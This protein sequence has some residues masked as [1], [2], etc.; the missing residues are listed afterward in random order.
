[1]GTLRV[2]LGLAAGPVL[3]YGTV[4]GAWAIIDTSNYMSCGLCVYNGVSAHENMSHFGLAYGAGIEWML[5]KHLTI[6]AEYLNASLGSVTH[7][8]P[9]TPPT[10]PSDAVT[11]SYNHD[12]TFS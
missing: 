10:S 12:L 7:T 9:I 5:G 2:R 1:L 3:F 4:G 8:L 6:K 11:D